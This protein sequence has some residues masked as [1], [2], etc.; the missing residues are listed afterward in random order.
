[1]RRALRIY[2]MKGELLAR[3]VQMA[4]ERIPRYIVWS[5]D[6]VDLSDEWQRKWY[7][8]QV[9]MH[10]RAED[11]ARLD[12]DEIERLLSELDLPPDLHRLWETYFHA[13]KASGTARDTEPVSA[14][15]PGLHRGAI[16]MSPDFDEPLS[17]EFWAGTE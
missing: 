15:V 17:E 7:I 6:H 14:R 8:R 13:R 9:L 1:M 16:W 5:T 12:W 2:I 4:E 3:R 11:V 10:G